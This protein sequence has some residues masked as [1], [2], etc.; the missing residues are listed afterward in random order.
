MNSGASTSRIAN[1]INVQ[2]DFKLND[3]D[4][5]MTPMQGTPEDSFREDN[6]LN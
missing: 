1:A 3:T 2:D 5:M 6:T 4:F